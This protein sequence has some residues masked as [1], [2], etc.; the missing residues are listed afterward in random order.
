[1]AP[2]RALYGDFGSAYTSIARRS[3]D[4]GSLDLPLPPTP[5]AYTPGSSQYSSPFHSPDSNA[6]SPLTLKP[7]D[8]ESRWSLKHL[9]RNL[10][11]NLSRSPK[12]EQGSEEELK[13]LS[14][15][16]TKR[17]TPRKDFPESHISPASATFDGEFPRPLTE[18][19][20][21]YTPKS[22]ETQNDPPTPT[23][24]LDRAMDVMSGSDAFMGEH[25][26]LY[27]H[28]YS[29]E[30]L[31]SMVPDEPSTQVGLASDTRPSASYGDMDSKPY[32]DDLQ[33]L[34][35]SSSIY[36]GDDPAHSQYSPSLA[37][38][39]KSNPFLRMSADADAFAD[40]Y[41]SDAL[42]RY[43]SSR[44]TSRR[45]SRPL[46]QEMFH[47][48][49]QKQGNNKTDTISKFID[50]YKQV[51][52]T[53]GSQPALEEEES[54][55][56]AGMVTS[57]SGAFQDPSMFEQSGSRV[58]SDLSRIQFDVPHSQEATFSDEANAPTTSGSFALQPMGHHIPGAPPRMAAP[59][60]SAFEYDDMYQ[61]PRRDKSSEM[62]SGIS[63]YG[64]TRQLLQLSQPMYPGH[65]LEPSSSYS[66]PEA[67]PTPQTPQE[68]LDLADQ[69]FEDAATDTQ[70]E[71]IPAMWARRG[72]GNLLRSRSQIDNASLASK[73]QLDFPSPAGDEEV[74]DQDGGDWET[75]AD[76]S[77]PGRLSG[78]LSPGESIADYSTSEGSS[79]DSLG[80]S[81]SSLPVFEDEPLEPGS[82][83]FQY[84]TPSP[85]PAHQHPFN[86]SP[87]QLLSRTSVRSAPNE[88]LPSSPV[89]SP[90]VALTVPAFITRYDPDTSSPQPTYSTPNWL[91]PMGLSDQQTQELLLSG[92]NEEILYDDDDGRMQSHGESDS[93]PGPSHSYDTEPPTSSPVVSHGL[94]RQNT[95]DKFTV[96]GPQ[97]NL[98]GTPQGTGMNDAGSS[99]A[100]N[101]SPGAFL[102]STP[103]E[104]RESR[105]RVLPSG[106]YAS[107]KETMSRT[108]SVQ[109]GPSSFATPMR[110]RLG[111]GSSPGEPG[112]YTSPNRRASVTRVTP[113]LIRPTPSEHEKSPSQVSLFPPPPAPERLDSKRRS[114]NSFRSSGRPRLHSRAAV[115]GQTKL[116]HMVLAPDAQSVSSTRDSDISRLIRTAESGRPSTSNTHTPLRLQR[117]VS[118]MRTIIAYEHSPH[119]LC[120]ERAEDPEEEVQRRKL[121]W[122]IFAMFCILPPMLI[123]YRWFGDLVIVNV[124]KGRLHHVSA[125]PKRVALG[126]GI[127]VNLGLSSAILL[128]ILIA[129]AMGVL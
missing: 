8:N 84:Q 29:S 5:V 119:L 15:S 81:S 115:P 49:L 127:A 62:F 98:T 90:P 66:Q 86:S 69:I 55:E 116:R 121:S 111:S 75:V 78:R 26:R 16:H 34:Y 92:P 82:F 12:L 56:Q 70:E 59:L 120:P 96:V 33:S 54:S 48:S 113:G 23:S 2:K 114:R 72:S 44:R 4:V 63:S 108:V 94:E 25:S 9:T 83:Q 73:E 124:T 71:G 129:H 79:R 31:T 64:D 105:R 6:V 38:N 128:P 28:H 21:V 47:R 52:S 123:L 53:S 125:K 50:E 20:R 7:T 61:A 101:S 76:K 104:S 3:P 80:F 65:G 37:S 122:W 18:S 91:N 110:A 117:S 67:P 13:D 97:G 74:F 1:M 93:E 30:P 19:Y 39:R 45:T 32:Y 118:T 107:L 27:S 103:P 35:P 46:T 40:E 42:Y 17:S 68:A 89:S 109:P 36:T 112:F 22:T 126:V 24:P 87:P 88:N 14:R 100:D 77:Q 43:S 95:F 99:A 51:E 57:T 85:M 60:A 58:D 106:P 10:T 41:K 11:K 102:S